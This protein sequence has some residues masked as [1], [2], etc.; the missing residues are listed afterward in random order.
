MDEQES[1]PG[2][3][4]TLAGL[5]LL[6]VGLTLFFHMLSEKKPQVEQRAIEAEIE[7]QQPKQPSASEL[8]NDNKK[9]NKTRRRRVR[10][11]RPRKPVSQLEYKAGGI[12]PS[13]FR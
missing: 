8:A 6:V 4:S 5:L 1:P 7:Q 10:A 13:E 9:D 2:A 11:L 12:S 3:L